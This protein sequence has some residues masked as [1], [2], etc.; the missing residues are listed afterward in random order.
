MP[1]ST[2]FGFGRVNLRNRLLSVILPTVLGTL[3]LSSLLGYRFLVREKAQQEIKQKLASQVTL[4]IITPKDNRALRSNSSQGINN[5]LDL[6]GE[7]DW[8]TIANLLLKSENNLE[9]LT[10]QLQTSYGL[11]DLTVEPYGSDNESLIVSFSAKNKYYRLLPIKEQNQVAI[12]FVDQ[13]QRQAAGSELIP[14]LLP[15]ALF[16]GITVTIIIILLANKLSQPLV[17]LATTA[18][19][20]AAG[21]LDIVAQPK[22][23]LETQTLASSFNNLIFQVKKLLEQQKEETLQAK[24]LRDIILEINNLQ[25]VQLISETIVE[26]LHSA[27]HADRVLFYNLAESETGI[28]MAESLSSGYSS[29]LGEVIYASE[30]MQELL[31]QAQENQV[32][33]FSNIQETE[34]SPSYLQLLEALEVKASLTSAIRCQGQVLGFLVVYQCREARTWQEREIDLVEQVS[35]QMVLALDRLD[36]LKQQKDS[37]IKAQQARGQ[38]EKRA[39][40][41]L[42]EVDGLTSGDLTIRAKITA[43]EIGTIADSYNAT[44]ESLHELVTQVKNV[45]AEVENTAETN[46]NLVQKLAVKAVTQA[47]A[48]AET[49]EQIQTMTESIHN[50]SVNAARAEKIVQQASSTIN[51]G[52]Q[53]MNQAVVKINSL[54]ATV[55][56]TEKK[57]KR[58]GESSQE[59]SQ[60]VNSIGRFA[61]QTHLLALKASI[62]AARAGEQGKGFAVIAEEVRSLAA[63]SAT[64]TANID[65]LVARIQLETN[66]VIRAMAYG[67]EQVVTGTELVQNT[68]QNLGSITHASQEIS[69]LVKEIAQAA[70]QQSTTSNLV[71]E[72]ITHVAITAQENSQSATEVSQEIAKLLAVATKLQVGIAKFKT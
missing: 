23:T 5:D 62:E 24:T 69:Q 52:D 7:G 14:L 47:T 28:V 43:D 21:D 19:R 20:A 15:S 26:K 68:R 16:M 58:L 4:Q 44:I 34:F 12:A 49:V 48:I 57:V 61:A 72:N 9:S 41:L 64:A 39:W 66:E 2:S 33:E 31:T 29:T 59:I 71:N 13:R 11:Q 50:V 46:E 53:A 32:Q 6:S 30:V 18:E 3:T 37:E 40:Q 65:N 22:G 54:Q 56:E 10:E 63:Q 35:N 36:F 45:A 60:V 67:T 25:D 17:D 55:I 8:A 27:L 42:Q 70:S 1:Q 51:D 38:L